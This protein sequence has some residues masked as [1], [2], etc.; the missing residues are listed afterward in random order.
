MKLLLTSA[1]IKTK[2]L[3]NTLLA[4]ADQ[5]T[6]KL[7]VA[8]IPTAANVEE[9]D[10]TWLVDNLVELRDLHFSLLDIVDIAALS[11]E[12][13][14]ERLQDADIIVI[15]GGKTDYLVEQLRLKELDGV[16][17][18][19]LASK[20]FV[21]ISA[22]SVMAGPVINPHGDKGLGWVDFLVVPHMGAA[23]TN[24]TEDQVRA[25]G[26]HLQKD[27]YW[28]SDDAAVLVKDSEVSVVGEGYKVFKQ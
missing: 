11:A 18:E 4:L 7:K 9:E 19:W 14:R 24:R 21:G 28:L 25:A 13:S 26:D 20:I 27:I 23:F 2:T 6:S 5:P 8:F 16:F 10:K 22:G 15:G 3:E 12:A 17:Q 1:G